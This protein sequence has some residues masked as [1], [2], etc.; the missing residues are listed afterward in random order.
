MEPAQGQVDYGLAGIRMK[1]LLFIT[2]SYNIYPAEKRFSEKFRYLSRN[3]TGHF[4]GIVPSREFKDHKMYNFTLNGLY[5]PRYLRFNTLLRN[6]LRPTML[7]AKAL[8]IYY[9]KERYDVVVALDP[10]AAGFIGLI[11]SRLTGARMVIEV[12]GNFESSF[13]F[14]AE[15]QSLQMKI[16]E[17]ITKLVLPF[18]LNRADGVKLVYKTQ[19]RNFKA[20]KDYPEKYFDFANLVPLSLFSGGDVAVKYILFLGFPWYLKGVDILIMAFNKIS[21]EF[22]D[23]TLKIVGHCP[24]KSFFEKLVNGNKRIELCDAVWH[25]DAVKLMDGCSLFVLPSRTDSLPRVLREAMAARKP[26][27]A[28]DVDGI[29]TIVSHGY[30][31][32]LFKSEDVD[33][34]AEKMRKVLG[35]DSYA[36][37][38][39][40]NGYEYVHANLS[41]E[42]YIDNYVKM[43]EK[44][45]NG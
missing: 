18:M 3:F 45:I 19:L 28:S 4:L 23:Y 15:R 24:D 7:T 6:L 31:G 2:S 5:L 25:E 11:V 8:Y 34:L 37:R 40:Q 1:R 26:I 35:D 21:G 27:I 16:K 20:L 36:Q 29:P 14:S 38:L 42:N 12:G 39:A 17:Q 22:P 43:I 13:R 44:V 30:N 41:E 10:L 33:D 32:L 9:F